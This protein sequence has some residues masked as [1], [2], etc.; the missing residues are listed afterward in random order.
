[1]NDWHCIEMTVEH[2]FGIKIPV[3]HDKSSGLP[4]DFQIH[5]KSRDLLSPARP[6]ISSS[7]SSGH[8]KDLAPSF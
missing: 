1:M 4:L 6:F 8:R 3:S 7:S 2:D 5:K